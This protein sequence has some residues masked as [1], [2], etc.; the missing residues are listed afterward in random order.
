MVKAPPS[1]LLLLLHRNPIGDYLGDYI[2][3]AKGT[4]EQQHFVTVWRL[5]LGGGAALVI[6]NREASELD[7]KSLYGDSYSI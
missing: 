3:F 5:D 6:T 2:F 1:L 7:G 4:E